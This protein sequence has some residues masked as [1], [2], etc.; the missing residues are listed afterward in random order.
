MQLLR[1]FTLLLA[2]IPNFVH[3]NNDSCPTPLFV[4]PAPSRLLIIVPATTQSTENWKY[5]LQKLRTDAQAQD[6]AILIYDH[7]IGFTTTGSAYSYAKELD[8]CIQ[9]K[10]TAWKFTK[11]TLVGHSIGGMLARR[12]YLDAAS[13]YAEKPNSWATRVDRILLFA[14]VNRGIPNDAT[15]WSPIVNW[16]LR[17]LPHPHFVLED[18]ASGSDF[19]AD[20]RIAWLRF[21]GQWSTSS[22]TQPTRTPPRI[23]QYWGTVDSIVKE[24]D[25]ADLEAFSGQVLIH[26][27]GANHGD[28]QRLEPEYSSDASARWSL[29]REQFLAPVEPSPV[30]SYKP[31]KFLFILRGI[32]DST[33]SEWVQTLSNQAKQRYDGN[34]EAPEYGYFTAA[35]FAIRPIRA[36]NIPS[37]RDLYA[38]KLAENPA[39]EFDVI[40]HSNG[41]YILGRSMA[42]TP[43]MKFNNVAMAAPVLPVDFPWQDIIHRKQV[44]RVRYDAASFDWPVGILCPT[45]RALGF[46][47]VGPAGLVKFGSP[48]APVPDSIVKMVGWH[49]GGHGEALTVAPHR[50]DGNLFH[51]LQFAYA[52]DDFL[53]SDTIHSDPGFLATI[54]RMTPYVFW[55][56]VVLT[57]IPIIRRLRSRKWLFSKFAIVTF[58]IMLLTYIVLDSA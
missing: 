48:E 17:A 49:D 31:R 20:T 26:V 36:K 52:G 21:F 41:T 11:V 12:A 51:L 3:A 44:V 16:T 47:D 1:L 30:L 19:I 40:S 6:L 32:R 4:G 46:D 55:L 7:K 35:Q 24:T 28:L 56:V 43:S 53:A 29:F 34:V 27:P 15:W 2:L 54:S 13:G 38:Q 22:A 5:F 33:S 39:T 42:T 57:V 9:E 23:F 18:M 50:N 14:S 45:L 37:F 8:A 10:V 58:S 25:N